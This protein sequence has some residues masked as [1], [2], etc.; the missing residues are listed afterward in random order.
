LSTSQT[1]NS[2]QSWFLVEVK[3]LAVSAIRVIVGTGIALVALGGT[4]RLM[5]VPDSAGKA[6]VAIAAASEGNKEDAAAARETVNKWLEEQ[7]KGSSGAWLWT[8]DTVEPAMLFAVRTWEIVDVTTWTSS[9]AKKLAGVQI[10]A[11][12]GGGRVIVRVD[13]SNQVGQQ[14]TVLWKVDLQ[15]A[16]WPK[17]AIRCVSKN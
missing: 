2:R 9:P 4:I 6:A 15:D 13:S 17:K 8:E 16:V 3:K 5:R 7:R 12:E 14:I 11:H 10:P 1:T